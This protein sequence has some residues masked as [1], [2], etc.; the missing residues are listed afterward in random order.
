MVTGLLCMSI[1]VIVWEALTRSFFDNSV[2]CEQSYNGS[3]C[4][5]HKSLWGEGG[6]WF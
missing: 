5:A 1:A 3:Y 4:L 6:T 2:G